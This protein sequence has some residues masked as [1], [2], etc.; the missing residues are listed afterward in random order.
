MS[1]TKNEKGG[2][3]IAACGR[4]GY[5]VA[6]DDGVFQYSPKAE[7]EALYE[8]FNP[9]PLAQT[10]AI[11][12]INQA[13]GEARIRY[14]T[15]SPGQDATYQLKLQDANAFKSAGYPESVIDD[16]PFINA[17]A[18][19]NNTSG[20]DAADFIIST[21]NQW[22]LLAATIEQVRRAGSNAV[23]AQTDWS[24]CKAAAQPFIDQLELI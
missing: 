3:F 8:S 1:L 23:M 4:A 21:A 12:L 18:N 2:Y 16:Y 9:L 7:V 20:E 17:E 19:A 5:S 22:K 24:Q 6:T 14:T 15:N 11:N 10:D 13:A